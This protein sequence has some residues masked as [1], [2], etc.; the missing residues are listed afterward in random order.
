MST[1]QPIIEETVG[2]VVGVIAD[3]DAERIRLL[4]K[5]NRNVRKVRELREL[6]AA[7]DTKIDAATAAAAKSESERLRLLAKSNRVI[8]KPREARAA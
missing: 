2:E 7:Y 4:N 8:R 3:L 6:L 1:F 5:A